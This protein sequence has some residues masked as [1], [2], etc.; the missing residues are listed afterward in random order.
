MNA[1][2]DWLL[3]KFWGKIVARATVGLAGAIAAGLV[4]PKPASLLAS[5]AAHGVSLSV[6][7]NAVAAAVVTAGSMAGHWIFEW[8]KARRMANPN[9]PAV[10]TDDTKAPA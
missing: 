4:S 2:E 1:I 6:D 8:F 3:N 5:A 9:S 7:P 10:Q